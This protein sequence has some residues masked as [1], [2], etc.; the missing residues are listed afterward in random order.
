MK[1]ATPKQ[2]ND[3]DSFAINKHGIPGITLMENAAGRVAEA[4]A[5]ELGGRLEGKRILVV[6][7]KGNNGGD[8]FAAARIMDAAGA[9][10]SLFLFADPGGIAG[11][12]ATNYER[13]SNTGVRLVQIS[14]AEIPASLVSGL[15][16]AELVV[17]GLFG[18]GFRGKPE[19]VL[20]EAITAV[21]NSGKK[22]VSIDIP[23]GVNGETGEVPDVCIKADITVTFCLPKAGMLLYPGCEHVGRLDVVDIGI[24]GEAVERAGIKWHVIDRETVKGK[25]PRRFN[26]SNKGDYGRV[27]IITGSTGMT[28]SGCLSANAAMRSGAG[29]VYAGVPAGLAAIYCIKLT[30]PIIIPLEDKG[31]GVLS[32][33]AAESIMKTLEKMDAAAIGPGLSMN[34][35]IGKIVGKVVRECT[36]PLV[37][38]ADGLNALAGDVSVLAEK[39]AEIVLTPHPGEMA[40]LTGLTIS[41]IQRD[42]PAA[43]LEL[44]K[45]YGVI[46]V[47]KGSRTVVALPDGS[48]YVNVT[49]NPGMA[50]AGAGDVLTGIISALAGQGMKAS[51][52]AMAGVYLHGLAG[53]MA[54]A[55]KGM[56]G[57]I[58]GDIIE[59]LP[60]A[61][62]ET[63][64]AEGQVAYL[65]LRG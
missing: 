58:A 31:S 25:L 22:V 3:I 52:A 26:E 55:K 62:K 14:G 8:A 30:E 18:T 63:S 49:G 46:V 35:D 16:D 45:R 43:A 9:R 10:V 59:M 48:L 29:L 53:D 34:S 50:S 39:K 40:R 64:G 23:S 11:D 54:A 13:L 5:A 51:D 21:N 65:L 19:G 47:L 2:M 60:Y 36:C 56:H 32:Y 6:A 24:P 12:A 4:V 41:E 57:I 61:I 28:G 15:A 27:F 33:T 20:K 42:R 17:D 38:D 1:L 7:G 37:I 44:S